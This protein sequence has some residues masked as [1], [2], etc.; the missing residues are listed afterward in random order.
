MSK[1]KANSF[2]ESFNYATRGLRL[3]INSQKNFVIELVI[4]GL[5]FFIATFLRFSST[6]KCILLLTILVVLVC[7]LF[8][9][10]IEFTLDATYKNSYSKLVE[11]AKDISAGVVLLASIFS[12]IIGIILFLPY[13]AE[14]II[15]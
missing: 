6:D 2:S 12:I 14:N 9:S 8:N 3:A 11:M 5:A 13:I 15:I 4:G 1:F 7:E 10:A